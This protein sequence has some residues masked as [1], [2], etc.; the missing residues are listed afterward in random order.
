MITASLEWQQHASC[1][2]RDLSLFFGPE[3][4]GVAERNHREAR[5]IA[6]CA[7]C[8]AR[9]P[10]LEWALAHKITHGV[11]GGVGE[12]GRQ[13][14]GYPDSLPMCRNDLHVMTEANTYTYPDGIKACRGCRGAGNQRREPRR[15]DGK[16]PG[17]RAAA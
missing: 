4:E 6:I 16:Q 9:T 3:D 1:R 10:C 8:T 13:R 14:L 11:W 2:D 5:A 15:H 12:E 7:G 17:S